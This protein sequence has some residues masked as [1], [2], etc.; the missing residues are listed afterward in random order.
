MRKRK[1]TSPK[2]TLHGPLTMGAIRYFRKI[3]F[4]YEYVTIPSKFEDA[5]TTVY[6]HSSAIRNY[7]PSTLPPINSPITLLKPTQPLNIQMTD[8]DYGLHKVTQ[9]VVQVHYVD[10]THVTILRNKKVSAAINGE[11]SFLI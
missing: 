11:P 5:C 7:N 8:E 3:V 1:K 2:T 9:N 4:S 10:C 6:K